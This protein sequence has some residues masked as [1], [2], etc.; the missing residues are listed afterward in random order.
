MPARRLAAALGL[1]VVAWV[2][3][4][5]APTGFKDESQI[6]TVRIIASAADE[7]Y[8]K[9]GDT[10]NVTVLAFDGRPVQPEPMTLYWLPFVCENPEGDA[11]F[12]CF[13]KLAAGGG[14]AGAPDGGSGGSGAGA[15]LK[16]GVDLTPLLPTGPSF[17]F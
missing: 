8:A 7:P 2:A 1:A 17:S 6:E 12:A 14:D 3:S 15:I 9:P 5:C 4:S 13:E 10:V 16:P 11:Y